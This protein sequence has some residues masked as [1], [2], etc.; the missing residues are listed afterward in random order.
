M[1]DYQF[2]RVPVTYSGGQLRAASYQEATLQHAREG[3]RLVQI[4]IE[5]PAAVAAEH[6]LIF[7]RPRPLL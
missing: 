1:Y 2:V 4:L 7:E 6:V 5:T 3:W